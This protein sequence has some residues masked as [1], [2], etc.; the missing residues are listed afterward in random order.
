MKGLYFYCALIAVIFWGCS[1]EPE[2]SKELTLGKNY[3]TTEVNGDIREYYVHVPESYDGNDPIPLVYML[4]G[5]SGN[6]D[7]TYR[8]SG[9]KEV[10]EAENFISVFPTA[11]S[12]CWI[13]KKNGAV[14]DTTRWNCF[15]GLFEFCQGE[16]PRD[17]VKFLRQILTELHQE[18]NIDSRKVYMAGFS[19]GGQMA[20][21]CA[22]EMSDVI[23]AVVQS[24]GTYQI[25]T[26]FTPLRNLPI[27]FE[28]GNKDASWFDS[29]PYP[30]LSAFDTLLNN[31]G[32]FKKIVNVHTNTFDFEKNFELTGDENTASIATFKGIP[33]QNRT[34]KFTLVK[35]LDHSYPNG[36]NAP[37]IGAEQHWAWMKQYTLP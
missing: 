20:F 14:N 31:Y 16:T 29:G 13:K 30:P 5:A 3:C 34:F 10:G 22:V 36:I 33:D 6:G 35:D 8:N 15:P 1:A 2:Q 25:D 37:Y 23:A 26:S 17:D 32:L 9:W 19:S 18:L 27:A 21:R 11:W 4:H 12:Y 24:G 28:L 7:I